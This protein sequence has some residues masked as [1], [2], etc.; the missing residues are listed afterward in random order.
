[1]SINNQQLG[2]GNTTSA[3]FSRSLYPWSRLAQVTCR[4]KPLRSFYAAKAFLLLGLA[5]MAVAYFMN[6][7]LTTTIAVNLNNALENHIVDPMSLG[8]RDEEGFLIVELPAWT[9]TISAFAGPSTYSVEEYPN[10]VVIFGEGSTPQAYKISSS[11][12]TNSNLFFYI[13][14]DS[15]VGADQ[16]G[17]SDDI[18]IKR[19]VGEAV[20][21]ALLCMHVPDFSK[22]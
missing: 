7:S 1:M 4:R 17:L 16:N 10:K 20:E 2:T 21:A 6:T 13:L 9:A 22:R 19:Y 8:Q 14:G 3:E 15:I 5:T 12:S 11:T 18:T